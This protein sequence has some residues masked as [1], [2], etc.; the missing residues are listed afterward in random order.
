MLSAN[1]I[2]NLPWSYLGGVPPINAYN[3]AISQG[4]NYDYVRSTGFGSIKEAILAGIYQD[5]VTDG[6]KVKFNEKELGVDNSSMEKE[7]ELKHE[8]PTMGGIKGPSIG[9]LGL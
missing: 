7:N 1:D 4:L 9:G 8:M 2:L 6:V 3:F 5:P